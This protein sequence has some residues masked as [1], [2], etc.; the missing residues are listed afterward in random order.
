LLSL[1]FSSA[2]MDF[3]A[4]RQPEVV[5]CF[6]A[7]GPLIDEVCDFMRDAFHSDVMHVQHERPLPKAPQ[8][9]AKESTLVDPSLEMVGAV[10]ASLEL[11][12]PFVTFITRRFV[13]G[14]GS[15]AG[16]CGQGHCSDEGRAQA[17]AS[18]C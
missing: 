16:S 6:V 12:F 1:L 8:L 14:P 13:Q 5:K 18:Y 11:S 3:L 17:S 4:G 2:I 15:C 10:R 9:P 7:H